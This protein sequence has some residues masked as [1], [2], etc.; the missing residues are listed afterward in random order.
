VMDFLA[1]FRSPFRLRVWRAT[2]MWA[3]KVF[4]LTPRARSMNTSKIQPR[5]DDKAFSESPFLV[6]YDAFRLLFEYNP[7]PMWSYDARTLRFLSVNEAA[8][9]NY[10][11]SRDEFARM[12]IDQLHPPEELPTLK[13]SLESV[14]S[15]STTA[16][17][18]RHQRKDGTILEAEMTCH[19]MMFNGR[20]AQLVLATDV[21]G[22]ERAQKALRETQERYR[23]LFDHAN[24]VVFTTDLEGNFTSL[25]K[26]GES[27]TG[28]SMEEVVRKDTAQ[29][30][31][32]KSLDLTRNMREKKLIEGGET[33][34]ELEIVRKDGRVATLAVNTSLTYQNGRPSGVRGIARDITER[35]Q[36]EEQLRQSQKM[37]ALGRLASGIAHD[38]NNL[39]GVI[40]GYGELLSDGLKPGDSL[41]TFADETL[42]AGKRAAA[43]TWQLLAFSRNQVLQPKVLDLNASITNVEQLLRRLI[44]EDVEMVFKLDA[45]LGRVKAD[46]GQIEQVILNLTVNARDALPQG[47]KVKIETRNV[48]LSDAHTRQDP[49]VKPGR[50]VL[51]AVIDNGTGMDAQTKAKIFEPFFTTKQNGRGTGLGLATVYGIVKQ[52][53]GSISV[54]SEPGKGASFMIYLP[55]VEEPLSNFSSSH[56]RLDVLTGKET[57][58]LVDDA[59][60]LRRLVRGLL[61]SNGYTVLEAR[62]SSEAAQIATSH[63][64]PIDLLLTDVVM[65]QLDGYELSDYLRFHRSG[66]KVLYMSGYAGSNGPGQP[67][68]KFGAPMLPKPFCKDALLTA[69]RQ[70]L[71]EPKEQN[72]A[73]VLEKLSGRMLE[74]RCG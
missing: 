35:K 56:G 18:W 49:S 25:N 45:D 32:P 34:Y 23:D 4:Q 9:R 69:V 14:S 37:E 26:A 11:Y 21:T 67:R 30:L 62:T 44:R 13:Q 40:I 74:S 28:Y 17:T 10:G 55:R 8:I 20:K 57:I 38:F 22:R 1:L 59:E 64:G 72:A 58:L 43:L 71:D 29:I 31:G 50:Y 70:M 48:D 33:T 12:T 60:P 54:Q 42:K 68:F 39:L 24:D 66:M 3:N 7:H 41:H 47:G 27:V 16:C 19:A 46:P 63:S 6:S 36:L 65:P 73:I 51:L 5:L 53:G 52:S 2:T 61:Q 15:K